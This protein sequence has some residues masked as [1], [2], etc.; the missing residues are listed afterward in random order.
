[1]VSSQYSTRY[2]TIDVLSVMS[3][4][5]MLSV[6]SNVDMLSVMSDIDML[7]Y[8]S[9]KTRGVCYAL[10]TLLITVTGA[11][12]PRTRQPGRATLHSLSKHTQPVQAP[13]ARDTE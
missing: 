13:T 6:M 11:S 10:L 8:I 2:G 9:L 1:M 3:N 12:L 4:V 5:D 7:Y